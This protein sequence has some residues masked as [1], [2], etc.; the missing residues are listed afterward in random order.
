MPDVDIGFFDLH[1]WI[2]IGTGVLVEDQRVTSHERARPLG[3]RLDPHQA[4]V[5]GAPSV[6]GD[7]LGGDQRR[8]VRRHVDHLR[9]GV[10]V[11]T[12]TGKG[13]RQH[14]AVGALLHQPHRRIFRRQ[15]RAEVAVDPLHRGVAVGDG[16]FGDEVVHVVG[17]VLDRGVAAAAAFLDDDL[18]HGRVQRIRRVHRRRATFD[19][20]AVGALVDDDQRPLELTH[21]LRI[22]P[23]IGLERLVEVHTGWHV[24]ERAPRPHRRVEGGKLVVVGWDHRPEVL[25]NDLGILP[26][27]GVHVG[28]QHA[29][30]RQVLTIA[31]VDDLRLILRGHPCQVLALGLRDAELLVGLLDGIGNH[32]PVLGLTLG[33]LDVVVDVVEVDL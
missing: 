10:L 32:V 27:S 31:V 33:G 23:E 3:P 24:D 6:L 22:D 29:H 28:E 9:S 12:I 4:S 2:G 15:L 16:S 20:V 30:R 13:N 1:V 11:L 7:G 21:V 14:L 5:S 8:R 18:H 26:N 19:I 25:L 17:P